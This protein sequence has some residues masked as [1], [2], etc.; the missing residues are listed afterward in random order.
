MRRWRK[1]KSRAGDIKNLAP[2][3]L[4]P[5]SGSMDFHLYRE[6]LGL[7]QLDFAILCGTPISE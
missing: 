6:S 4:G 3:D 5:R 2:R 1:Y 7:P